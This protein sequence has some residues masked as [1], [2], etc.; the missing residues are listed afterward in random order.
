MSIC[1]CINE[2]I[3]FQSHSRDSSWLS[4]VSIVWWHYCPPQRIAWPWRIQQSTLIIWEPRRN[5]LGRQ[6][7]WKWSRGIVTLSV[8]LVQNYMIVSITATR[9]AAHAGITRKVFLLFQCPSFPQF[10]AQIRRA[11]N[12]LGGSVF[13][14]LNWSSP[15]VGRH[16]WIR[17]I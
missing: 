8:K 6:R 16:L 17:S 5:W 11:I 7:F 3:N 2:Y 15:K 12:A 10:E 9:L 1:I 4:R 13:P 14:K